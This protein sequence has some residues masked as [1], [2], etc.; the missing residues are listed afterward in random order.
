M[1]PKKTDIEQ[2]I[3]SLADM[4]DDYGVKLIGVVRGLEQAAKDITQKLSIGEKKKFPTV[5]K[6]GLTLEIWV[7]KQQLKRV[8]AEIKR[9]YTGLGKDKRHSSD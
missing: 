6:M 7:L 1:L 5:K 4:F 2:Q 3:Q 9:K 8:E